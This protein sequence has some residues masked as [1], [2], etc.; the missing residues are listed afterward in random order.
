MMTAL[1]QMG[2]KNTSLGNRDEEEPSRC[3]FT[4]VAACEHPIT[5]DS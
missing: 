1:I 4:E 2:E 5:K 3:V